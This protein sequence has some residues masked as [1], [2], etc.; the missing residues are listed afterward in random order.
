[1]EAVDA[2]VNDAAA[3]AALGWVALYS[4]SHDRS[5]AAYT[6][7]MELNPSDADIL[8]E[9]ADALRHSGDAEQ[10]IP[11]FR[12]AIRLNPQMADI[13]G[14]DLAGA[15]LVSGRYDEAI[16]TVESMRRPQIAALILTASQAL[17][18]QARGGTAHRRAG[19]GPDTELLARG[20][21]HDGAEPRRAAHRDL[22]RGSEARRASDRY[23]SSDRQRRRRRLRP[24][25]PSGAGRPSCSPPRTNSWRPASASS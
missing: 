11:I 17:V 7:A 23:S 8:A 18:G 1:M 3:N 24:P 16:R 2:D 6:R 22:P 4:R 5:L 9:Y 12:R 19:P 13:Y 20:V 14:K 21:G 25:T 10:A 15:L